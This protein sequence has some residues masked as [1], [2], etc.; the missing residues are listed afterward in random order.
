MKCGKATVALQQ[1]QHIRE[2]CR[3]PVYHHAVLSASGVVIGCAFERP[4]EKTSTC[5]QQIF[6]IQIVP[7]QGG[8]ASEV[9]NLTRLSVGE[10]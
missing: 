8:V 5:T 3:G 2:N 4:G 1:S 10:I 7:M 9:Q 6:K